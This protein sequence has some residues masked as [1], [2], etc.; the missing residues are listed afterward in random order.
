MY[1]GSSRDKDVGLEVW[2]ALCFP[3]K[4]HPYR[5]AG[6]SIPEHRLSCF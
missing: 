1:D 2:S 4:L 3:G 6:L 5:L